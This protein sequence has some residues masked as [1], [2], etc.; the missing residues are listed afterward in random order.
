MRNKFVYS[1]SIKIC[2]L[3]F[4]ELVENVFVSCW[5]WEHFPCKKF[6]RWLWRSGSWLARGQVNMADKANLVEKFIQLLKHWMCNV[7]LGI[8]MKNWPIDQCP[9]QALQFSVHLIHLLSIPLR[10]N[11]FA[12]IQKGV[13][14][15]TGRLPKSDHDPFLGS[16]LDLGSALELLLG[17]GTELVIA[18]CCIKSTFRCMSQYD[19][20]MFIVVV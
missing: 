19:G 4:S 15:H 8:V 6:L 20:E 13:V 12:E 11:G 18:V 10:C 5:L 2:A 14:D 1:S 7:R 9:L 3:G 17:P 16:N